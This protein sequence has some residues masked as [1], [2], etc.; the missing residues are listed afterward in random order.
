MIKKFFKPIVFM[1]MLVAF[2]ASCSEEE[3]LTSTETFVTEIDAEEL[4]ESAQVFIE[5]SFTGEVV[6][7]A[8]SIT[9]ANTQYEAV[10]TNDIN[11]VFDA[12]GNLEAFGEDVS[13]IE[14]G[15]RPG[16]RFGRWPGGFNHGND[17]TQRA[18]FTE[19]TIDELPT[20]VTDYI[21]ANYAENEV[22][23]I[24]LIETDE[25]SEYHVLIEDVGAVV[26]DDEGSFVEVNE[27]RDCA[28]FE[29]SSLEEL[30]AAIEEYLAAN[31]PD[32]E[33]LRT[34]TGTRN[35]VTEI[36]VLVEDVG[37]LIFDA[38]GNFVELKTCG[39][40]RE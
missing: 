16:G 25:T 34:R 39:M 35:D 23:K 10:L 21:N 29:S 2:F 4:P 8:F 37:V 20:A 13:Y 19:L 18:Q 33:I 31:Y 28:N 11:L 26:F 17:S 5:D 15:G 12:A 3:D 36:H 32:N 40:D 14:C 7:E 27:G 24:L 38:E 30:P 1:S 22:L 9:G 6:T